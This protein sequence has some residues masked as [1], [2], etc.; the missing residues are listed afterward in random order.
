MDSL[1]ILTLAADGAAWPFKLEVQT[2]LLFTI[3][4]GCLDAC[5]R[6]RD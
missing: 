5:Y 1:A 3:I 6:R 4:L 2:A